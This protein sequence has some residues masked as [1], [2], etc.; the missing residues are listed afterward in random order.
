MD[1]RYVIVTDSSCDLSKKMIQELELAVI[2]LELV[3]PDG[4]TMANDKIETVEVYKRLRSGEDIKTSAVNV[5]D[6][7]AVMRPIFEAG[8][9]ILYLGF[10]SGLSSTFQNVSLALKELSEEFPDRKF[11]AV[12]TL[13]AS[14]GQ[15]LL[16]YK[17]AL[18]RRSGMSLEENARYI[19]SIKL[20]LCHWFTVDDLFFLK[21]GGRVSGVTAALGTMLSIKPILHMDDEGHLINVSKARGRKASVDELFKKMKATAD[22]PDGQTIFISHGDCY[23]DALRLKEMIE[24]EFKV[25]QIAINYVGPVIG[26]HSGPG[27]L[28]LFFIGSKR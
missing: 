14:M 5:S 22:N 15:G 11:A 2:Q 12:D 16:V 20:K 6:A 17:A 27:T 23:D 21:R 13:A 26:S 9:D 24:K 28:A 3:F 8:K 4:T 18:A 19:E 1:D 10:S 7:E 25:E